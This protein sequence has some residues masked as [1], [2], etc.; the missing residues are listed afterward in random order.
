MEKKISIL[1]PAYNVDQYVDA[2]LDSCLN[3]D[4][5]RNEYEI[6]VV[7]DGST[8]DTLSHLKTYS[9]RYDNICVMSQQN[10]GLGITRNTLIDAAHGKY[11]WFVDA[12]DTITRNCLGNVLS[13]LE[14]DDLDILSISSLGNRWLSDFPENFHSAKEYSPILGGENSLQ[15]ILSRYILVQFGDLFSRR[16]F[17]TSISLSSSRY[18]MKTRN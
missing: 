10:K 13:V 8:D 17:G 1:I 3:Q 7:N 6:I 9:S 2:C 15:I 18:Y 14:T 16:N 4:L 11:F 5:P 12:D